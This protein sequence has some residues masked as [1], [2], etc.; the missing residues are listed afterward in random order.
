MKNI[1]K[2]EKLVEKAKDYLEKRDFKKAKEYF[3]KALEIDDNAV[4]RNNIALTLFL[5]GDSEGAL[6]NLQLLFTSSEE[7]MNPNVYSY[8][9]A[10]QIYSSIGNEVQARFF[11]K[12]AIEEFEKLRKMFNV[13]LP[14]SVKEYVIM[15]IKSAAAL[16]D[17]YLIYELFNKWQGYHISWE[18]YYL[19]GVACF[20]MKKYKQ[21]ANL[22]DKISKTIFFASDIA[23]IAILIQDGVIPAFELEYEILS[24]EDLKH[25]IKKSDDQKDGLK[26]IIDNGFIRMYYLSYLL[27]ILEKD[28]CDEIC[29]NMLRQLILFT[30]RWGD[31]LAKRILQSNRFPEKSKFIAAGALIEKGVYNPKDKIPVII[32]GKETYIEIKQTPIINERNEDLEKILLESHTLLEKSKIEDAINLLEKTIKEKGIYP[33]IVLQLANIYKDKK[34][35]VKSR[36]LYKILEELGY[37]HPE[38]LYDYASFLMKVG[39]IEKVIEII[40]RIED[41]VEKTNNT[42]IKTE[43]ERVKTLLLFMIQ[44]KEYNFM[45]DEKMRKEIEEKPISI[46]A[47]LQRGMKNKPAHWIEGAYNFYGLNKAKKR[48]EREKEIIEF[49]LKKENLKK[50]LFELSGEE[51]EILK[52]LLE[53]G[54]WSKIG[55]ITR[56]F[57]SMEGEGFFWN[58]EPPKSPLAKLWLKNLVNI[59]KTK[60]EGKSYKIVSIPVDLR[61]MMAEILK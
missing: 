14:D 55:N 59:G 22:W 56:K 61:N 19:A 8:A 5:L 15:I 41:F 4:L 39:E 6:Y 10:S 60:I 38:F 49:L 37:M 34:E 20:N 36:S 51:K 18:N 13:F 35:F 21:A 29:E 44:L 43:L 58:E 2:Y 53:K 45:E 42:K 33:P 57:C 48:N 1:E 3:Y 54:G 24:L 52:Y 11:L 17:H 28:V 46:Y 12:K 23:K 26:K 50:L 31:E 40:N 25:I 30:D 16:K 7:K 27:E 47:T 32:N 9:L